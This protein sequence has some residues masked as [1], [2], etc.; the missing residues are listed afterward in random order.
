[1]RRQSRITNHESRITAFTLIELLVVIAIIAVLAAMLLPALKNAKDAA[2]KAACINNLRQLHL[3]AVSYAA[4]YD[5]SLPP[6]INGGSCGYF[7]TMVRWP[8]YLASYLGYRGQ[9]PI[10]TTDPPSLGSLEIRFG[11]TYKSEADTTTH[12]TNPYYCPSAEGPY[13]DI[14]GTGTGDPSSISG[15][16][17]QFDHLFCDYGINQRLA[18]SWNCLLSQ[19]V[20]TGGFG[21]THVR[22]VDARP[23][24]RIL[25]FADSW[26]FTIYPTSSTSSAYLG[27]PSTPRHGGRKNMVFVDGHVESAVV[28]PTLTANAP[29]PF[30]L[31]GRNTAVAP[32][33][34]YV[35]DPQ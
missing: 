5:E 20:S 6:Q 32:N 14:G 22:L 30:N 2:K 12:G 27:A 9:F 34:K 15:G 25:L 10:S 31:M 7:Q 11:L 8:L 23:Y 3:A 17:I 1:M 21:G 19:W 18:G 24:D 13:A 4:D 26:S 35:M 33:I 29:L 28:Y 16:Y